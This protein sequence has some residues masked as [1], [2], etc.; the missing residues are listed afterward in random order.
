MRSDIIKRIF[1]DHWRDFTRL[2][3][4]KIR[5]VV[6]QEVNKI[7]YCGDL[8][9]GYIEF[10]C[11]ECGE[12]IKKGFTCKSRFCT[13]CGKVYVDN[14]VEELLGKLIKTKHRHMVFTIPEQLR[15]YF[16]KDRKMLSI[17]T[18]CAADA[19]KSWMREQNKSESF[20]PGIVA[21]IHTFGR[22]LKWNPHV[23]ALVTE[24]GAGKKTAWRNINFF[25]YEALRKRWQKLLLDELKQSVKRNKKEVKDLVNRLYSNYNLGFYVYAKGEVTTQKGV[26]KYVAR[27]TGRPA[28]AV[29]RIL[30]YDGKLVKFWY[31]RHGDNKRIEEEI[32][33]YE[34]IKRLIVHIPERGFKMVRYYGIYSRNNKHKGKFFMLIED[35]IKQQHRK[36][37]RWEYR[38]MKSFG[39]DPLRCKCGALMKLR[40]IVYTKY[41]SIR[42]M[43]LR[44]IENEVEKNIDIIINTYASVKGIGKNKI[45]PIFC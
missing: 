43:L 6:Y 29:S 9:K 45:E 23:H 32:D 27:Y 3:G 44:K 19:I 21:V 22:D 41:G 17:L 1:K 20:T 4:Y 35:K 34:F 5:K 37:R 38:I 12:T 39:V 7:M 2:Y 28:I 16:G 26:A 11:H 25:H 33:V 36:L 30:A 18:K 42:D 10:E 13:S 15:V 14:R 8:D 24:G 40:D 31:I